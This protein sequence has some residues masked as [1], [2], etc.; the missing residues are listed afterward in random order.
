MHPE[1]FASRYQSLRRNSHD[2][3]M[4]GRNYQQHH[5][6]RAHFSPLLEASSYEIGNCFDSFPPI[7][8]FPLIYWFDGKSQPHPDSHYVTSGTIS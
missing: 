5:V 4:G 2:H 3:L 7:V 6:Q 1:V 8:D